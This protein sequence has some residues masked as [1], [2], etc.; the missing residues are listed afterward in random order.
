MGRIIDALARAA[1]LEWLER[2]TVSLQQLQAW[3][4][5][6]EPAPWEVAQEALKRGVPLDWWPRIAPEYRIQS[7]RESSRG[8]K[9]KVSTTASSHPVAHAQRVA[10]ITRH[11]HGRSDHPFLR[12]L[13]PVSVAAWARG[14]GLVPSTVQ[15]Y[16]RRGKARRTP[17]I[18][19]RQL[20]AHLSDGKVPV[21][22]WD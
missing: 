8:I 18:A 21:E 4:M 20:V 19:F 16:L 6:A 9:G 10:A 3:E 17:P 1:L 2:G 12:W 7:L 13:G 22:A 11:A 14:R 15:S 5:G